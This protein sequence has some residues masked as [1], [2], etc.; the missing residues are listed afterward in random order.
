MGEFVHTF[1]HPSFCDRMDRIQFGSVQYG[2]QYGILANVPAVVVEIHG[3]RDPWWVPDGGSLDP[4]FAASTQSIE[5]SCHFGVSQPRISL[6]ER[7]LFRRERPSRKVTCL[8]LKIGPRRTPMMLECS[9]AAR[10]GPGGRLYSSTATML[11]NR[12]L[13]CPA[14]GPA[15]RS[16]AGSMGRSDRSSRDALAASPP[17]PLNLPSPMVPA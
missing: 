15:A 13:Q 9:W 8:N 14:A 3:G 12:I 4:G 1:L 17:P 7:R 11:D 5:A 2:I 6:R 10:T 16:S